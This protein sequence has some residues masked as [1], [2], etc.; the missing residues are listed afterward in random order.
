[1]P[2][3]RDRRPLPS[4]RQEAA[5]VAAGFPADTVELV[6][7]QATVARVTTE[8]RR[9]PYAHLACHSGQNLT[10]P[11][12]GRILLHDGDLSVL[13]LARERLSD[14]ELAFLSSCQTAVGGVRVLDEAIHLAGACQLAGYRHVIGTL[15]SVHDETTSELAVEVWRRLVAGGAPDADGAAEALHQAQ[16]ALR[17]RQPVWPITWAPYLHT[18]P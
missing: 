14:A 17:D 4:A 6:A 11:S 8:L 5:R 16:R 10:D 13:D 1:M 3:T 15:W 18:G 2:E 12:S 7:E 9:H